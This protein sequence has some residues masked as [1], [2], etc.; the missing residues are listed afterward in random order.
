MWGNF[1]PLT[2]FLLAG[3][4]AFASAE[5]A[6]AA[7]RS[8]APALRP[9]AA[10]RRPA[11]ETQ[12]ADARLP[13]FGKFHVVRIDREGI[14][15]REVRIARGSTVVWFNATPGYSSVVFNEG[16]SLLRATQSPTLFFL[17]PDGTYVSAAFGPGATA[18]TAFTRA[19][20]FNY[21]ATGLSL[22]DRNAF[23]RVVV[24]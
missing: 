9:P 7:E 6:F 14:S 5:G 16:E 13:G 22:A 24:E 11:L 21:F 19:G 23:A 17:A 8:G 3:V 4:L 20:T 10:P 2:L 1:R 15:P 18:S 12:P